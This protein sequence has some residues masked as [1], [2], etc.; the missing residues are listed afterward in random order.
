M[1]IGRKLK[2][3]FVQPEFHRHYVTFFPVYEPLH[4]LLLAGVVEDL[5]DAALFDRRFDTDE[6]L[7]RLVRDFEP[8]IVAS[9]THT[10]GELFNVKRIFGIVKR[11][12]P[13]AVTIVGGQHATLLPED[14][15]DPS[16]DLVCIGPGE[17]T[18]REVVETMA[19][20]GRDFRSIPGLAVNDGANLVITPP[21]PLRSGVVSWPR[22]NRALLPKRYKSHYLNTFERRTTVYTI[23]TSG[24]PHRCSFCSLW[25][26]ARGTYRRRP[27]EEIV[28]DICSQPQPY[29][30]LTDDNTFSTESHAHEI[31]R[32]LKL[33]G[34]KK[35]ILAYARTD[36]IVE[37]PDLFRKWKEVGLGALVVGMEAVSDR[38]LTS[39][40]KRTSVDMNV[41]AQKILDE[42]GIENWAH[43][44]MMPN[45]QKEDFDEIWDFIDQHDITYPVFVPMTPVPGTP[46]FFDVKRSGE[47]ATFDYGFFNLEYMTVKT[48]LPKVVWYEHMLDL[49]RKSCSPGVLWR[50]RKSPTFHAR[51]ALLRAAVMRQTVRQL[52]SHIKE[53]LEHERSFCYAEAEATL[54]PGLRRDYDPSNYYNSVSIPD[55]GQPSAPRSCTGVRAAVNV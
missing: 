38:H 10:A 26:A 44:V 25:A 37:R 1:R 46:L 27:P 32:L 54:P 7:A 3:L 30:H 28:E 52:G 24:C 13:H 40:N 49:Y 17:E 45:Y 14:L 33:R 39:L 2:F 21:R 51:P 47:L 6:N 41:R 19:L 11:E 15:H 34:V 20:G 18:F 36:T 43:F 29:V 23:T 12:R 8:D 50:R 22:F 9:T 5:A 53:Q 4:A 31:Q 35:K 48:R 55:F 42:L 16:T